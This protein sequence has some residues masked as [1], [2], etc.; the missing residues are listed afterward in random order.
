MEIYLWS[1]FMGWF[2]SVFNL[3]CSSILICL[4]TEI[5]AQQMLMKVLVSSILKEKHLE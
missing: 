4:F 5:S 1:Y 2:G 3:M